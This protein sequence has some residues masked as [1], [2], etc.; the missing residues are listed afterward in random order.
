MISSNWPARREFQIIEVYEDKISGAR[1]SR[2]GLDRLMV[3]ARQG[4]FNVLL[5]W[6]CDRLARPV[7]HF[8]QV[9]DEMARLQIEFVSFREQI[10]TGGSLGES[11]TGDCESDRRTG[12]VIN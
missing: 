1:A 10:D 2:L 8:L 11:G 9:L 3:D 12:A 5:V 7:T 4:K 6:A